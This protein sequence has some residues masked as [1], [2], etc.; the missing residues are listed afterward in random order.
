MLGLEINQSRHSPVNIVAVCLSIVVFAV[1]VFINAAAAQPS[2]GIFKNA[3]NVI[4]NN[5]EVDIT[6]DGWTFSTWGLIYTW[7]AL[8]LVYN[9]AAIFLKT[10]NGPLYQNPTILTLVFHIFVCLNFIFNIIWLFLWEAEMF[11][12]SF[13]FLLFITFSLVAAA[14]L[15]HKNIFDA[16]SVLVRDKA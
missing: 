5:N 11:G 8:W 2:L 12:V 4:S 9:V 13:F 14:I 16:E 1:T 10:E 15:S 6:P 3:T 7:Q